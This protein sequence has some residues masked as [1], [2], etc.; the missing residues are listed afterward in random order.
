[1]AKGNREFGRVVDLLTQAGLRVE[2]RGPDL[3]WVLD[4]KSGDQVGLVAG[5]VSGG[6]E[7]TIH[8][9]L[10]IKKALGV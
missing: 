8:F 4:Q 7:L 6:T 1:M 2:K 10:P 5:N 3:G 9:D